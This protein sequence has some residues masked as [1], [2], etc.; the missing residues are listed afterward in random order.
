[1]RWVRDPAGDCN[2]LDLFDDEEEE[3]EE[4]EEDEEEE[5]EGKMRRFG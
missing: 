3:E 5:E 1:M 2:V 4:E